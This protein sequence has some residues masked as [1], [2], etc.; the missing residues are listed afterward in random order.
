MKTLFS[1]VEPKDFRCDPA[2]LSIFTKQLAVLF[3]AGIALH[4]A[5]DA[6]IDRHTMR[7]TLGNLVIPEV[8]YDVTNGYRLS[9]ALSKY[10]LVFSKTYIALIRG[11]EETGQL[12]SVLERLGDWLE[13]QNRIRMEVKKALSYPIF[14]I[15]LTGILTFVMFKTFVPQI[16]EVVTGLGAELPF[17]TLVLLW[18]VKTIE[19]PIFWFFML[20]L[21]A[22]VVWYL[23]T[24]DG[25]KKV[26]SVCQSLP[27]IGP[28]LQ[29]SDSAK[30]AL[31][32]SLL[33]STGVD[34]LRSARLAAE[35]S[36]NLFHEW[37]ARRINHELKAGG[38]LGQALEESAYYHVLLVDMV[39]LGEETGRTAKLLEKC[40]ELLEEDTRHRLDVLVNLLE[41]LILGGVS[42]IV[43][44]IMVAV[45]LPMGSLL[46][47]L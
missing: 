12:A 6:L 22:L 16:L 23:R 43:G 13:A 36:G 14:V 32:L 31:T 46:S 42:I 44:G 34:I 27:V 40:S 10:P 28:V 26:F 8:C 15:V 39:R 37:D 47:A 4:E 38:S 30:F 35:A 20:N 45:M 7:K 19:S 17:P 5:L 21:T 25:K 2:T 11:A 9:H 33:L 29:A 1:S 41:P 18:M 24:P 3:K